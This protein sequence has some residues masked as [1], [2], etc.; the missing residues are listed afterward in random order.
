MCIF[1]N[2]I[3]PSSVKQVIFKKASKAWK[4]HWIC[5][6]SHDFIYF[7]NTPELDVVVRAVSRAHVHR[8]L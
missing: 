2:D 1:F 4:N 3:A 6:P 8:D 5:V 7:F